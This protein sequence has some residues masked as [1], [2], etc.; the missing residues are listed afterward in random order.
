MFDKNT[1]IHRFT[2]KLQDVFDEFQRQMPKK[3]P[4]LLGK[5]LV[6]GA[7]YKFE[8]A[9]NRP[10]VRAKIYDA[11][12]PINETVEPIVTI[13]L[14]F[15]KDDPRIVVKSRTI[16]VERFRH[17]QRKH[18]KLSNNVV[19]TV[20]TLLKHTNLY[21]RKELHEQND[22]YLNMVMS[23]WTS[24]HREYITPFTRYMP[25]N[26]REDF[27]IE[28]QHMKSIGV[29]FI[30]NLFK[31]FGEFDL[32]LYAE[33]VNRRKQDVHIFH[34]KEIG[35]RVS[36]LE[37]VSNYVNDFKFDDHYENVY[38]SWDLLPEKIAGEIA[39]LKMLPDKDMIRGIGVRVSHNEYYL[40]KPLANTTNA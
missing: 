28:Y 23:A 13:G 40:M 16:L 35:G 22:N 37:G 31:K 5:L 14:D 39:M 34:V 8:D 32:D 18:K 25:E 15:A 24:E 9:D 7:P 20:R 1:P 33:H 12:L 10:I 21:T 11:R 26:Y 27:I 2:Q 36:V 38:E 3:A 4:H 29:S 17:S 19:S 30:T 6:V